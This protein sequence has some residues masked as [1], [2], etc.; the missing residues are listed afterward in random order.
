MPRRGPWQLQTA[1]T[2]IPGPPY[3]LVKRTA[4]WVSYEIWSV[5][6]GV[7]ENE[8]EAGSLLAGPVALSPVPELVGLFPQVVQLTKT[9]TP[10]AIV[11]TVPDQA[12]GQTKA[13]FWD[14]ENSI[15]LDHVFP[16]FNAVGVAQ[17]AGKLWWITEQFSGT[18]GVFCWRSDEDFAN[19]AQYG[20]SYESDIPFVLNRQP[21]NV[22]PV[23]NYI[24]APLRRIGA[25]GLQNQEDTIAW[26]VTSEGVPIPGV[27]TRSGLN[28]PNDGTHVDQPGVFTGGTTW[29]SH[30]SRAVVDGGPW[31]L[32]GVVTEAG[33]N[34]ITITWAGWLE[35][36][37]RLLRQTIRPSD[38]AM[39]TSFSETNEWDVVDPFSTGP[40]PT[41]LLPGGGPGVL[42]LP[43]GGE[44]WHLFPLL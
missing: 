31:M 5:V 27:L 2:P 37:P 43:G 6:A 25:G 20:D 8:L 28:L 7:G 32:P 11:I 3:F 34:N 19:M 41:S 38:G 12:D 24:V 42:T 13:Y 21:S 9:A 40:G 10:N 22:W 23:G 15:F 4:N 16:Q 29:V 1:G 17:S 14:W 26:D 35:T 18:E 44:R 39:V 30:N 36:G 33:P